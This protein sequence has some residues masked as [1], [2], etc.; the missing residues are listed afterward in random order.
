MSTII[1][2]NDA[3]YEDFM[4]YEKVALII[5]KST[6]GNCAN[7][8]LEIEELAAKG[9]LE[10]LVVGKLILDKAGALNLKRANPWIKEVDFLPF[11]VLYYKGEKAEEFSASKGSY[12]RMRMRKVWS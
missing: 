9:K 6:C 8:A 11:T 12:L 3:N 4:A 7:Y 10:G 2:V 1:E 5:S